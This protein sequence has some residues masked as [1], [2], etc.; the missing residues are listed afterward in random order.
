[1]KKEELD[2]LLKEL[3]LPDT[4][5]ERSLEIVKAIQDDKEKSLNDYEELLTNT[6]KLQ[7]EY[8]N[9][10]ATKVDDFFNKGTE[11]EPQ[12]DVVDTTNPNEEPEQIPT[13]DDL[14]EEMIGE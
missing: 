3:V 10:K 9:L 7:E 6:N 4:T 1:M 12:K 13:Y 5:A 2:S 11:F 14:V 8:K